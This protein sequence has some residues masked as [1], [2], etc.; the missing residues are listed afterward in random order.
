ME[1]TELNYSNSTR[2]IAPI[3]RI[4]KLHLD[5]QAKLD[6]QSVFGTA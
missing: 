6:I 5:M 3:Q 1:P 4:R 2:A